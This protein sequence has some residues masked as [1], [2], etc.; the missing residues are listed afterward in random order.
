MKYLNIMKPSMT[1]IEVMEWI[2][3]VWVAKAM[4]N[5]PMQPGYMCMQCQYCAIDMKMMWVHFSNE[6]KG[7]QVS[8]NRQKSTIQMPFKAGLQKYIQVNEFDDGM[9]REEEDDDNEG[10]NRTLE[11]EFEESIG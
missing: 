5:V 7:L 10:W 1:M 3:S 4:K 6:Y 8:M 2:R 11:E 9:M